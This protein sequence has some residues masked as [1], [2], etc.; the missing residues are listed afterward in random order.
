[1]E[2]PKTNIARDGAPHDKLLPVQLHGGSYHLRNNQLIAGLSKTQTAS[3]PVATPTVEKRLREV[4]T[5]P[6]MR[7]RT[8]QNDTL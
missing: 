2:H 4:P 6:G 1:M 3:N 5:T 7:S 8:V